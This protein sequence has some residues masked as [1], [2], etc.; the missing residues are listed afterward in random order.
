MIIR[1][2]IEPCSPEGRGIEPQTPLPGRLV[3]TQCPEPIRLPSI[4]VDPPGIEPGS[5]VCRA[6]VFP[7]DHEPTMQR[8]AGASQPELRSY[9]ASA[10]C[11]GTYRLVGFS[12]IPDGIEPSLSWMS[13][14]RLRR[15]TTGSFVSS[16]DVAPQHHEALDAY[17]EN[18]PLCLFAYPAILGSCRS[19]NRTRHP[20]L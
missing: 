13:A 17:S 1:F 5:P 4:Q 3:S 15:W 18:A 10:C 2:T 11:H 20:T 8:S 12:V 19:W 16:R 7:L 9:Q 14:M 6:G